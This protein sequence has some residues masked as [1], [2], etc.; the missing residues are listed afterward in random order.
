MYEKRVKVFIGVSLAVLSVCL[1]RLAQ[2]QLFAG[3]ASQEEIDRIKDLWGRSRQF[4]TLR[5]KILDR[6]GEILAADLPQFQVCIHYRL[7]GFLDERVVLARFA[8]ARVQDGNP[9]LYQVHK[10][11]DDRRQELAR[12]IDACR[13]LGLTR[14]EV[15][16]KI[17]ALNDAVW[18]ARTFLCWARG[19][20][21]PNLIA[22][23]QTINSVPLSEALAHFES[24]YP[25][26]AE[27]S[28]RV[29]KVDLGDLPEISPDLPLMELRTEDE[30][31]AAQLAFAD[32]DEVQI[33]PRGQRY[34]PFRSTAAQT[35]GWVG[36]A[37]QPRDLKVFADDPLASY[38]KGEV[39]GRED[40]V[41]YVCESLLRG[42]RGEAVYDIDRQLVRETETEYGRDVRLTLD[43]QLQEQIEQ[44]LLDPKLNP[45]YHGAPMA[46]AVIHVGSGDILALVSLPSYDLNIARYAFDK[47]R[48]DPNRP[49][50]NRTIN[51]IYPPG[52]VA[53]PL[54]LLA[55][56]ESGAIT[57]QEPISCPDAAPPPGW[58]RCLIFRITQ[59]RGHDSS[60]VNNARN[61]LKG[62]CNIYFS[63]LADRIESSVLQEWLFRFGHGRE[64]PLAC[65]VPPAPGTVTRRLKQAPG[66]IGST[67][68]SAATDT[69]S[70]DQIPPLQRRERK[71]FGI[72][73]GNFRVTPLQVANTFATLARRGRSQPPRLFLSP[74][75]PSA[76]EPADLPVAPANMQVVLE[77][78]NAV[79]NERGGSAYEVFAASGLARHGVRV[80]GKTGSTERP[81]N[82]WFG[83]FAQDQ[84]GRQIALA[85]V[86]EGGQRGGSE[87]G[88]LA[89]EIFQLC[90]QA[91]YL[92]PTAGIPGT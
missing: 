46:A 30:V 80:Y 45:D 8:A 39:C 37:T 49:L 1:L 86:I 43:I 25:D 84:A 54:I 77:G 59:G 72:G 44:R 34:Y 12:I 62:S 75:T 79:V 6:R 10:E 89:R 76:A 51:R 3:P 74:E 48:D 22:R 85:V 52:S 68:I 57:A 42:R 82:A 21:D 11:V 50:I 9:S 91:G 16:G 36:R 35:I 19:S 88:P 20:P 7:S 38:L 23:Y 55:G 40:G 26:P 33:L 31:F 2:M 90:V 61:A 47:L 66:E 60:W 65:P 13:R 17:K 18:N 63:R 73:Q 81:F 27:R 92:G 70:F 69:E 67:P 71:M 41:E 64:I 32:L 15:E 87:A 5:G 29:A 78:M 28:R 4:Q 83:G 24:Q 58:P 56:L 53:K 14:Q